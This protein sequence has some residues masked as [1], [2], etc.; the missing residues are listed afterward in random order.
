MRST[1]HYGPRFRRSL[2]GFDLFPESLKCVI[3]DNLSRFMS[4]YVQYFILKLFECKNEFVLARCVSDDR[5][6]LVAQPAA[7]RRV[8]ASVGNQNFTCT[9]SDSARGQALAFHG[10][11]KAFHGISNDNKCE[12]KE[13]AMSK[14]F[15]PGSFMVRARHFD[16][17]GKVAQKK[18]LNES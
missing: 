5:V 8:F 10:I 2:R 9:M 16:V 14:D 4:S 15:V 1:K 6:Y 13:C 18:N 7:L 11:S 17:R 3:S 12:H